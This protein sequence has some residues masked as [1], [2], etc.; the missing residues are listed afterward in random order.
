MKRE[1]NIIT[2]RA[3]DG[4]EY[5]LGQLAEKLGI[6]YQTIYGRYKRYGADYLTLV[7]LPEASETAKKYPAKGLRLHRKRQEKPGDEPR[8]V[9][10]VE[11]PAHVMQHLAPQVPTLP[12]PEA[13]PQEMRERWDVI[14]GTMGAT[15]MLSPTDLPVIETAFLAMYQQEQA[16]RQL[17]LDG[18]VL[19]NV[20]GDAYP[21]PS[22]KIMDNSAKTILQCSKQLGWDPVTRLKNPVPEEAVTDPNDPARLLQA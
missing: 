6:S 20:K 15:G 12:M 4:T 8:D 10:E 16:A 11:K 3:P 22:I 21:H 7:G 2:V 14:V 19:F 5:S 9:Y 17:A 13:I 1:Y 18:P